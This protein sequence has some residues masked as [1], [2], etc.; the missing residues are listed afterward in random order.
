[1][2]QALALLFLFVAATGSLTCQ[3]GIVRGYVIDRNSKEVLPYATCIEETTGKGYVANEMG[4]LSFKIAVPSIIVEVS[5]VG[6]KSGKFEI[7]RNADTLVFF[8]LDPIEIKEVQVIAERKALLLK[9]QSGK[10]TVP[11]RAIEAVPKFLGESDL[12]KSLSILPGVA[13]GMEGYSNLLVRGG[14]AD[15][16]LYLLDGCPVFNINHLGGFVSLFNTNAIK[17]IDV[18]KNSFPASFGGKASS[19]V[20]VR[21]RDGDRESYKGEVSVGLLSS[22]ILLEGPLIRNRMSFLFSGRAT[23][24]HLLTYPSRKNYKENG[25]GSFN[26]YNFYD[27]NARINYSINNHSKLFFSLYSGYDQLDMVDASNSYV[28]GNDILA[29]NNE[30]KTNRLKNLMVSTGI[31]GTFGHSLFITAYTYFSGYGQNAVNEQTSKYFDSHEYSSSKILMGLSKFGAAVKTDYYSANQKHIVKSSIEGGIYS[32]IPG[33]INYRHTDFLNNF[34][35]DTLYGKVASVSPI[36]VSLSVQDEYAILQ[37]LTINTGLRLNGFKNESSVFSSIEPRLSIQYRPTFQY[38]LGLSYGNTHQY[39]HGLVNNIGGFER[40]HWFGANA[41]VNPQNANH[42][43]LS[44]SGVLERIEVDYTIECFYKSM[45]NLP[46]IRPVYREDDLKDFWENRFD[47]SGT[48]SA[49]GTEFQLTKQ[50][51]SFLAV[52]SYTLMNSTR[53]YPNINFGKPFPSDFDRRHD[54]TLMLQYDNQKNVT[55]GLLYTIKSGLPVNLPSGYQSNQTLFDSYLVYN[56][57]NTFKLPTYHRLDLSIQRNWKSPR[58]NK[59][60][61]FLSVYN[62]YA[63]I[64]PTALYFREGKIKKV[65]YLTIVPS[66]G[67]KYQF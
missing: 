14:N 22:G 41:E 64:N 48:G 31:N 7:I 60:L 8:T 55:Y 65:S 63:R 23:Y 16:N 62:V 26:N 35:V 27:I 54:C 38:T 10:V 39:I 56:G 43:S 25:E 50:T 44:F 59:R 3:T 61:I 57:Y 9:A 37:N 1:M 66:F 20:D 67:Y 58:G 12:L 19:V 33:E 15:Q 4:F 11:L 13:S 2:K 34:S 28:V 17:H 18:Y 24:F 6:Y 47:R 49:Y 46:L 52:L 40:V 21:L 51:K 30:I 29:T 36:E 45:S 53:I 5:Y 32:I 42:F